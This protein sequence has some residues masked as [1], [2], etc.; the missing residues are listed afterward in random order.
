MEA[1]RRGQRMGKIERGGMKEGECVLKSGREKGVIRK[2]G[3]KIG[4]G[5]W[6]LEEGSSAW[7][8]EREG[9]MERGGGNV[10][11]KVERERGEGVREGGGK[12]VSCE[13]G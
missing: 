1:R 11:L 9:D 2:G 13:R 4:R 3:R 12:R 5:E 6:K 7:E 10:Y 8:K